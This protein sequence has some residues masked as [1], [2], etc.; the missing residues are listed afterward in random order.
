MVFTCDFV[1]NRFVQKASLGIPDN[2]MAQTGLLSSTRTTRHV[3]MSSSFWRAFQVC[4][5]GHRSRRHYYVSRVRCTANGHSGGGYE[6]DVPDSHQALHSSLYGQR[7]VDVHTSHGQYVMIE[8]EDDGSAI[9][10]IPEFLERRREQGRPAAG[11]FGIY[12]NDKV[13]QLVSYSRN[14]TFAVKSIWKNMG[15]ERCSYVRNIV[16]LNR[17][18][19]TKAAMEEEVERWIEEENGGVVPPGNGVEHDL[20]NIPFDVQAMSVDERAEYEERRG[21][22]QEALGAAYKTQDGTHKDPDGG[23]DQQE[24]MVSSPFAQATVH[25]MVGAESTTESKVMTVESVNKA[26]DEVRPYLMADGGD[27]EVERV[28]DDGTVWLRLEGACGSCPA[29]SSTLK[30]GIERCLQAAFGEQ[31]T[32]VIEVGGAH[33]EETTIESVNAHLDGLRGALDAYGGS[34]TVTNVEPPAAVL[35]YTGPKPLA[36]GLVAAIKDKFPTLSDIQVYDAES[37]Q[38]I[39]F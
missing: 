7:D 16:F 21:K 38:R 9:V 27:V 28:S 26:L 24:G 31:L 2:K 3:D 32:Q 33:V 39:E 11:I 36:Y 37:L 1:F 17:A 10:P 4:N 20:W 30:L 6:R 12:N 35:N 13:L 5:I 23:M 19:Q 25:R 34:V 8:G 18:M 29:S 14:I 15:K 22:I